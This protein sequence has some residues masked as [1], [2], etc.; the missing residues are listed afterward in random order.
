MYRLALIGGHQGFAQ[1]PGAEVRND[2]GHLGEPQRGAGQGERVTEPQVEAAWQAKFLAD[3]DGEHAAVHE[4]R[5]AVVPCQRKHAFD[6]LVIERVAVHGGE[7]AGD[8][9]PMFRERTSECRVRLGRERI[10]H[11]EADETPWMTR[12]RLADGRFIAG[13]ARDERGAGDA[14]T[15]ELGD[16]SV[17]ELRGGS[18]RVPPKT[19]RKR[20]GAAAARG[21]LL[22]ECRRKEMAVAIVNHADRADRGHA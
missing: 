14:M 19:P 6:A 17:R 20:V 11:E 9:Q 15:I 1:E 16:P 7:E 5:A 3:A 8:S 10:E 18:R 12:H 2:H 4:Y 22:E 21:Q 13:Y